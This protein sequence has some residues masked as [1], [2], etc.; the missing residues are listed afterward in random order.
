MQVCEFKAWFEGFTEDMTKLPTV[1][2][3]ARIKARIDEIDGVATTERIFIDRYWNRYKP[4]WIST[5]PYI[6]PTWTGT[7]TVSSNLQQNVSC[8]YVVG[9][10]HDH[11]VLNASQ[12]FTALG[13][14]EAASIA[15]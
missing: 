11:P 14:A 12:A 8:N 10:E 13:K 4:F 1:K 3:W 2:Q 5:T 6:S 9:G 15:A 7:Q